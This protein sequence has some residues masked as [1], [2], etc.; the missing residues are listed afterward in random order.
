MLAFGVPEGV[1]S[2]AE[3][4]TDVEAK[5]EDDL[6]KALRVRATTTTTTKGVFVIVVGFLGAQAQFI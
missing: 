6:A 1:E 4:L 5:V 2:L 3:P